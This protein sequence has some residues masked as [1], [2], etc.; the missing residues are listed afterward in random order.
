MN[1]N[2]TVL[3]VFI[4]VRNAYRL[5][6]DYQQMVIDAVR[7]IGSQ[8]DIPEWASQSAF[9][10]DALSSYRYLKQ[11]AW[12]WL[13]MMS[14][15]FHFTKPISGTGHLSLSILVVS[16]TGF[17]KGDGGKDVETTS[18]FD[19]V[20]DSKT[21]FAF[22]LY[23]SPPHRFLQDLFTPSQLHEFLRNGIDIGPSVTG[24]LYDAQCLC[25]E[26]QL[27][28]V[29]KDIVN[30]AQKQNLPLELRKS[31]INSDT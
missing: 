13:P 10:G 17:V 26:G 23:Q 14:A 1:S 25:S 12:D 27:N 7:Y 29:I 8:F 16:D 24:R 2:T 4:N 18:T 15:V 19:Q 5:L 31:P 30:S 22:F 28:E 6:H 20:E 11:S 3:D 21:Q 9:A